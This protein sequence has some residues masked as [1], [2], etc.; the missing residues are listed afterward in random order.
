MAKQ[1]GMGDRL[2]VD[3]FNISG[4]VGSVSSIH[5][6]P[7]PGDVTAIDK[8]AFERIGLLFDGGISFNSFFNPENV[9]TPKGAFQVL[10]TLPLAD[11]IVTYNAGAVLG[12]P[13][14]SCISKQVNYDG[15][16]GADASLSFATDA[17]AN[18]YGC[19]WGEQLTAGPRTDTTATNGTAIDFGAVSTLF[20]AYVFLHVFA[21]TG[22]SVTVTVQDSADNATFLPVTGLAF[23]AVVGGANGAQFLATSPTAT[24]RR[25]VRVVTTGTFSNAQFAVNF[26]RNLSVT[27]L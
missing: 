10:K 16:R 26:V 9:A 24:I 5:G 8:S 20:G 17:Q 25:Y 21:V 15:T 4:D 18:A 27:A 19:I 23:T 1:G 22:T 6:G 3:G 13:A 14:A 7:A 12:N 2:Y 11:R